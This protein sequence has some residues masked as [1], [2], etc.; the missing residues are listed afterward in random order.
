MTVL[1]AAMTVLLVGMILVFVWTA[2]A[3]RA[4]GDLNRFTASKVSLSFV[5]F[6]VLASPVALFFEPPKAELPADCISAVLQ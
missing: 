1:F 4:I 6:L 2:I 3:W 5:L